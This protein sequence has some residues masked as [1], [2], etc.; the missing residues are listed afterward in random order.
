MNGYAILTDDA[1][2]KKLE[3]KS[4]HDTAEQQTKESNSVS[5]TAT[6]DKFVPAYVALDR[7][8]LRFYAKFTENLH[9]SAMESTRERKIVFRLYVEDFTFDATEPQIGRASCRERV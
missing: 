8:V 7:T 2:S 1:T 6:S 4:N 9:E 3:K 5:S